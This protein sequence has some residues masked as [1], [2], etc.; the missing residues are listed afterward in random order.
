[1]LL[2]RTPLCSSIKLAGTAPKRSRSS[3]HLASALP[4]RSPELNSQENIWQFMRQ[5]WLLNRIFK[6]FD[7]IVDHCCHAWNTLI[8]QPWK[9]MS[10]AGQRVGDRMSIN[11]MFGIRLTPALDLFS[12]L[13][14]FS[15]GCSATV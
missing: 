1:L 15:G 11:L 2:A 9:I 10:I 7:D 8:D 4:P 14:G 5:N 6:S 3:Q 12:G 13:V